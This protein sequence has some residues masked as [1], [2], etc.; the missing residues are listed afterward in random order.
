MHKV[1]I[2]DVDNWKGPATEKRPLSHALDAENVAINYYVLGSG[3]S[4]AFGYHRHRNQE[5]VFYIQ[6]GTVI[7]ETEEGNVE[8]TAG[9]AVRFAPGEW[10]QGFN[11]G[12]GEVIALAVGAPADA[13]ETDVLREC[14]GCGGTT[15][16]IIEPAGDALVTR[17]VDCGGETGRFT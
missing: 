16:Q 4:F 5:E 15:E 7:F 2:D 14:V 6:Q 13:G 12:G 3:E 9:E 11:R 10:Q 8:V 17:C 1:S